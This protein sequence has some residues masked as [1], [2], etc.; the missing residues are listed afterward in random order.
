VKVEHD[1]A[2]KIMVFIEL[3]VMLIIKYF[4]L[5]IFFLFLPFPFLIFDRWRSLR[6]ARIGSV[7]AAIATPDRAPTRKQK[8]VGF[9]VIAGVAGIGGVVGLMNGSA[10]RGLMVGLMVCAPIARWAVLKSAGRN[11]DPGA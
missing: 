7:G 8:T 2:W 6:R 9:S 11:S 3:P 10:V 4:D 1:E 5:N